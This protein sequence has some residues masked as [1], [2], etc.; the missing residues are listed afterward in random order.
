MNGGC[1]IYTVSVHSLSHILASCVVSSCSASFPAASS[2]SECVRMKPNTELG[3]KNS[4]DTPNTI[5]RVQ[6]AKD[7]KED[8]KDTLFSKPRGNNAMLIILHHKKFR[9]L[10][11]KQYTYCTN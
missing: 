2:Q 7:Y 9:T 11:L 4:L 5:F 1:C 3:C 10:F 6:Q 8:F